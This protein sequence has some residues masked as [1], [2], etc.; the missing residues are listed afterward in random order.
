[1][2]RPTCLSGGARMHASFCAFLG[3]LGNVNM[4]TKL[5][6]VICDVPEFW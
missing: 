2:S 3:P 4:K 5:L 1:L 6:A